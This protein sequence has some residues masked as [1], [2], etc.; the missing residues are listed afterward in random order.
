MPKTQQPQWQP[1]SQ[2]ALIASHIDGMLEAAQEQYQTLQS[3]R[4]KPHVLDDYTVGRV[5]E[6]FTVQKNDLWLF[7]EQLK[8]WTTQPLTTRQRQEVQRLTGQMSKLRQVI[9]DILALA[10]ELKRG[11]IEQMLGKSDEEVGLDVLLRHL[12]GQ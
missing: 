12:T 4:A 11:T 2:L 9:A 7:D 3:A 5:I 1:I 6:V 10:D 8:R